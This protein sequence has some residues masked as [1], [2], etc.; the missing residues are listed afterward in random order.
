MCV[1]E[2][3]TGGCGFSVVVVVVVVL[4]GEE[5]QHGGGGA[6]ARSAVGCW[7]V[8]GM[9]VVLRG[10]AGWHLLHTRTHAHTLIII[11]VVALFVRMTF[12]NLFH[13]A[14]IVTNRF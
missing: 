1:C 13:K 12:F 10:H 14:G 3:L 8:V 7:W 4:G 6:Y 2:T 9:D 11:Q 5:G